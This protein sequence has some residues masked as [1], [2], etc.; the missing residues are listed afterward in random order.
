MTAQQQGSLSYQLS[1]GGQHLS[2]S[3]CQDPTIDLEKTCG[4]QK[5]I[6]AFYAVEHGFVL[7][8]DDQ[9]FLRWGDL[10]AM[11][12]AFSDWLTLGGDA[13]H[14]TARQIKNMGAVVDL[15]KKGQVITRGDPSFGGE[16]GELIKHLVEIEQVVASERAFAALNKQGQLFCWGDANYGGQ[17]LPLLQ[18]IKHLCAS[19][20]AFAALDSQGR[21]SFL[22]E[23]SAFPTDMV[24]VDIVSSQW[25]FAACTD[26]GQVFSCGFSYQLAEGQLTHYPVPQ[27]V[28]AVKQLYATQTAFIALTEAGQVVSWDDPIYTTHN[29][30]ITPE[31]MA[32]F[33]ENGGLGGDAQ[34]V[35]TFLA[36]NPQAR[37]LGLLTTQFSVAALFQLDNK[38]SDWHLLVWGQHKTGGIIIEAQHQV[39][40][41]SDPNFT[42]GQFGHNQQQSL[43]FLAD[44]GQSFQ[45]TD[46]RF[47]LNDDLS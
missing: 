39:Q 22:G 33:Q 35:E 13:N 42:I 8:F 24:V 11:D 34:V 29:Q 38:Q 32:A 27:S 1:A 30:T 45:W 16:A 37:C 15:S 20:R 7:V 28:Q 18:P 9:H 5:Q 26:D 4:D 6:E 10:T 23:V 12:N 21:L 31:V 43:D 41:F 47:N 44:I 46:E 40:A 36:A 25:G 14:P 2:W 3:M 17:S 19:Q